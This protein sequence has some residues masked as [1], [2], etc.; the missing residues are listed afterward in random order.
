MVDTSTIHAIIARA[1]RRLR[2]QAA[3][4]TATT[5]SILAFAS[6]LATV[7]AVRQGAVSASAGIAIL[8]GCA[9]VVA[10]GALI[11][12]FGRFPTHIVA[13]RVDRASD[14]SDRLSTA[15][16]FER[17]LEA[18]EQGGANEVE[19]A[20]TRALM[21]AAIEDA[22]AAAPAADVAAATPFHRPRDMGAA[23]SFGVV[24]LLVSGLY[25][26][27]GN[28][29]STAVLPPTERVE[30]KPAAPE[31]A[32]E[33]AD[34]DIDYARD[35]LEDLR[36]V[37][38]TEREPNLEQFVR[39]VDNL[40][41]R[42]EM[43][44]LSKEQLLEELAKA[45]EQYMQGADDNVE[46]AVA[47]LKET[48]RELKKNSLTREVGKA[49]EKG[50]LNQARAEMEKLAQ[51]LEQGQFSQKQQR[52]IAKALDKAARKFDKKD[53]R[54]DEKLDQQIAKQKDQIR[55]LQRKMDQAKNQREKQRLTRQLEKRKRELKRLERE[56]EKRQRSAQ[57][58]TLKQLH[59]DMQQAS[60]SMR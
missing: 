58:R 26:P 60:K 5:T 20:Q 47:D 38:R 25:W 14:L 7:Y 57:R 37:A 11:G 18:V 43:G 2:L 42:A 44:E 56:R 8:V 46:Q 22:V 6:A 41:A 12:A 4:E 24:A 29:V 33:F 45:E 49:L 40:L 51:K 27:H 53:A 3:L 21:N 35:L 59:R 19:D 16:A 17:R 31:K 9:A 39:D 28:P 23:L 36:R 50:D 52:E 34:D 55:K 15:C 10:I 48:G 54:R 32:D 1:R 30:A 13:T